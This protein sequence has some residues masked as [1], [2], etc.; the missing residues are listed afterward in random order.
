MMTKLKLQTLNRCLSLAAIFLATCLTSLPVQASNSLQDQAGSNAAAEK[1]NVIFILIDDSGFSD[2]GCYGSEIDTP[3]LD[4]L[5]KNGLQFTQFYNTARCWP[6]RGSLMTGFYAQAVRRDKIP[7]QGGGGGAQAKRPRWAK[8]IP[9]YLKPAGYRNYHSGK[10]HIDGPALPAGFDRSYK[11]R[12]QGNFFTEKGNIED[13]RP[14][15]P[16]EDESNFYA[17]TSTADHA[18]KCLKEHA[19]EHSDRP[20]FSYVAFIAPHFPLHAPQADIDKYRDRYLQGW[21]KLRT[22][23]HMKQRALGLHSADLSEREEQVGPPYHFADAMKKLGDGEVNRPIAWEKLN[24]K[25]KQ[26][27]ATK[28]AIHAAMVDRIDVEVGRIIDQLKSMDAFDNTLIFFASDN[29]ASAEIMVRNGGHDPE[30]LPGSEDSYLCLGPGFSN[31]CNTPFR[32]HKTWVH[33]GGISSPL[34]VHWPSGFQAKGQLRSTPGHVVDILPTILDVAGIDRPQSFEGEALP[35]A[36]GRSLVPAF[37]KDVTIERECIWWMHENNFAIRV[38][39]WKLVSANI[40]RD[41]SEPK[42]PVWE[43]YNLSEDRSEMNNLAGQFPDKVKQLRAIWQREFEKVKAMA[44][45]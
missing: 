25:Q 43:L 16:A 23:R 5:A 19:E 1:P 42:Q 31:A 9:D 28:M 35:P 38:G 11:R 41:P 6:T 10:W 15:R 8:L 4:A 2:L 40:D 27:Q 36:H 30:A 34:I 26:F 7:G 13:D 17:T 20:F 18:I 45:K 3:N 12:N 32:R 24:D 22:E 29:G 21:D 14:V 39:D 44:A 37:S 33:E